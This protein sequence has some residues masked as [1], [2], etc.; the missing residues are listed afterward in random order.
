[1]RDGLHCCVTLRHVEADEQRVGEIFRTRADGPV[2]L[3]TRRQR[4][5]P[6]ETAVAHERVAGEAQS[7]QVRQAADERRPQ[8]GDAIVG[9]VEL[10]Q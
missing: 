4:A 7:V 5:Q 10:K 2:E 8:T 6:G 1:M 9:Q 3:D